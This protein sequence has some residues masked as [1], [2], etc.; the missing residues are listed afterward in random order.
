[1]DDLVSK[2]QTPISV[3]KDGNETTQKEDE[4]EEN[5]N[6]KTDPPVV[7]VVALTRSILIAVLILSFLLGWA[8]CY[9]SIGIQRVPHE[10]NQT[11]YTLK[12]YELLVDKLYQ[13]E[14]LKFVHGV[15]EK[16]ETIVAWKPDDTIILLSTPYVSTRLPR[17]APR[18]FI[19]SEGK[20]VSRF[21]YVDLNGNDV[22]NNRVKVS[23]A[24]DREESDF[25]QDEL[26]IAYNYSRYRYTD[27]TK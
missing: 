3:S 24:L 12:P 23:I 22:V 2:S 11:N 13:N 20:M 9:I 27:T 19:N 26:D 15:G 5:N 14:S 16:N 7:R 18:V 10:I 6:T 4:T 1:M 21:T 17:E 25:I 8:C